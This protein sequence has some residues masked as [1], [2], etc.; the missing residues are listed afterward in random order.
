ML[1]VFWD[2][3]TADNGGSVYSYYDEQFHFYVVQWNNVKTYEDNSNESFQA[4]LFDPMYYIT[5]TGDGGILLQYEDF[6]N[7]SNGS[8]GGGTPLHGGYC[9][10]GIEDHWGTT[11]LEYTIN[12]DYDRAAMPLSDNTSLFIS[13]RKTGSVWNLP[14]AQLE[15]SDNELNIELEENELVT[16]YITLSNTGDQ[17]SILSY[18]INTSPLAISAG[19]D[20]FGNHWIDSDLDLNINYDWI[21][22]VATEDNRIIFQNND[23]GEVVDIGFSFNY[24]GQNYDQ[25]IV[26]PNG[27]VGFGENDNQWS[28]E[29]IP[30]DDAPQNAIFAFWDD[31][32]PQNENNSCSNE[33]EG[34]IYHETL[35]DMKVIWFNDVIRC[36]S[37][38]DYEGIFDFQIVLHKNKIIDINYRNMD[39]YTTSATIGIQNNNGSDGIE[40]IYNDDYV[41][42][43]LRLSFKPNNLWLA[44]IN[45]SNTLN[46]GEQAI[47]D[48]EVDASQVN[49]QNEV[50]YIL[51]ESNSTESNLVVPI[52]VT[53][54]DN[55]I[56]GDINGDEVINVLDV[57][58]IVNLIVSNAEY[59]EEAD[60]NEDSIV[61][62]LDIVLLVNLIL[63]S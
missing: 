12:N 10:I 56:V 52:N 9:S 15:L 23:D 59:M 25:I 14:Q 19:N 46:F 13:T 51:V 62:V 32:N 58:I 28:N 3:L 57:V 4:I 63:N 8:Y 40:I 39:G 21:N 29:T 24:Y 43:N 17:E 22:I 35:T 54:V 16:D 48:V 2:D 20:N 42:E 6:N 30:S 45:D 36:G 44:P 37:N 50:S 49:G 11:G 26:N 34:N 41:H 27:W 53:F 55:S 18:N 1:A 7:T 31:L 47:Y 38:P 60:L 33:G 61:N 5:P